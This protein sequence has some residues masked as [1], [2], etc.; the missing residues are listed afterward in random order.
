MA[1][2]ASKIGS[3]AVLLP[4]TAAAAAFTGRSLIRVDWKNVLVDFF[5]GP[6]RTSRIMLILFLATNRK[7]L[8]FAW[9]A[10]VWGAVFRHVLLPRG[11]L[12][13]QALFH[14]SISQ[15]HAPLLETDYNMHKSNSTYFTDL[16]IART[17]LVLHLL[18]RGMKSV[19][20]GK[21]PILDKEGKEVPGKL[22][23]ALG[24][25]FCSW[26][27]EI[28]PYKGYEIWSRIL[29]WDRKWLVMVSYFVEKGKVLPTGFDMGSSLGA[30]GP[31]RRRTDVANNA[32]F[33]KHVYATAVSRYVFKKGRFTVHPSI[34]IEASGLLPDRPGE[35]WRGGESETGTPEDLSDVEV[36]LS[37]AEWDWRAVESKRREGSVF[38]D[39]FGAL[40]GLH[41]QFDGGK[42]DALGR[43]GPC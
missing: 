28:V 9:T 37:N 20:E 16:D 30:T 42:A 36:D 38:A 24:S 14:Y 26:K 23:T 6:G 22:G 17:H 35:G 5:M 39:H 1:S 21:T 19:R 40:D 29:S 43:F 2:A 7:N 8:I 41:V 31:V 34:L 32:D 10:R 11:P 12:P 3:A 18:G 4:L 15:S 33:Q 25:V 13:K 27:K